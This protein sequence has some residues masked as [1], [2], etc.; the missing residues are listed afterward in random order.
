VLSSNET[1]NRSFVRR[2]VELAI[3]RVNA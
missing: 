1:K 2:G 3:T